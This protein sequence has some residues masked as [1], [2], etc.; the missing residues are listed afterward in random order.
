MSS[1][2][3]MHCL[4]RVTEVC[5]F[6]FFFSNFLIITDLFCNC[7]QSCRFTHASVFFSVLF[8]YVVTVHDFALSLQTSTKLPLTVVN[9]FDHFNYFNYFLK[10]HHLTL[11]EAADLAQK[12]PLWRMMS[13]YSATQS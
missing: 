12:R 4:N 2:F 3:H 10:H 7:L 9:Y 5:H 8:F 1:Q 13:T 11:P 6:C